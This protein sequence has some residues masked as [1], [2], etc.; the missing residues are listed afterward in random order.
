M[1][2]GRGAMNYLYDLTLFSRSLTKQIAMELCSG[3]SVLD[4]TQSSPTPPA[5]GLIALV[6]RE[7]LK[8]I[9]Y[10]HSINVIH[11]DIKSANLLTTDSGQIK[12]TDFGVSAIVEKGQKRRSVIGTPY[13]YVVLLLDT[14]VAIFPLLDHYRCNAPQ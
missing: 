5:E 4:I 1:A 13:W 2:P 12:L 14:D 3:G 6:I 10:L 11:R 9:E 8:G 7:T